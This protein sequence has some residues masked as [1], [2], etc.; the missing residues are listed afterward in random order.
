MNAETIP[1][2]VATAEALEQF[3][4][5]SWEGPPASTVEPEPFLISIARRGGTPAAA[6]EAAL[7]KII[8]EYWDHDPW[9]RYASRV[10][11]RLFRVVA[12]AP[13]ST[14][15]KRSIE[16]FSAAQGRLL[17]L[18]LGP[19][20][21]PWLAFLLTCARH[22]DSRALFP[23]WLALCDLPAGAAMRHGVVAVSGVSAM[24]GV[25]PNGNVERAPRE[26][27][28][29][30]EA[31]VRFTLALG[32][33]VEGTDIRPAIA[34]PHF[35][36]A[37]E[38]VTRRASPRLI[39][40]RFREHGADVPAI[41]KRWLRS[42][43]IPLATNAS[44]R[45]EARPD[46]AAEAEDLL[47]SPQRKSEALD[48]DVDDFLTRERDYAER[49]GDLLPIVLSLVR[50]A[51]HYE[52]GN[53]DRAVQL[54]SEAI[55]WQ[56]LDP[57]AWVALARANRASQDYPS[58]IDAAFR[59]IR[60][61]PGRTAVWTELALSLRAADHLRRAE[62]ILR[63][64]F[65]R[66]PSDERLCDAFAFIL[67]RQ[68][69]FEEAERLYLQALELSDERNE[70]SW[71]GLVVVL[72]LQERMGEAMEIAKTAAQRF[73]ENSRFKARVKG[74]AEGAVDEQGV[75]KEPADGGP[76]S[77]EARLHAVRLVRY[78]ALLSG[79]EEDREDAAQLLEGI[80]HGGGRHEPRVL[81]EQSL[82]RLDSGDLKGA[83]SAL[84][85]ALERFPREVTLLHAQAVV[86]RGVARKRAAG[87][88][89]SQFDWLSEP[90][91]Q[92]EAANPGLGPLA[93]WSRL[94]A[95]GISSD[96]D[97]WASKRDRSLARF[98][99][100][101]VAASG[102]PAVSDASFVRLWA[103]RVQSDGRTILARTFDQDDA[104]LASVKLSSLDEDYAL[105]GSS[106]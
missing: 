95:L 25:E 91:D 105:L 11:R 49:T 98:S 29:Q 37:V 93:E 12:S 89:E 22:Q 14:A 24:P 61:F 47:A 3:L 34:A 51:R 103:D 8:T 21:D 59:A 57:Y 87:F 23:Q 106:V 94:L 39:A 41:A 58:A 7:I 35:G 40:D 66:F 9:G 16:R 68:G 70:H 31:F 77:T 90:I 45:A 79:R 56:P 71:D 6:L 74:L 76:T 54:A 100:R 4:I 30:V 60:R 20:A 1:P 52:R 10:W 97:E 62:Q 13:L 80:Q 15:G 27:E 65:H 28:D 67:R 99:Q 101:L 50:F 36:A 85:Q 69:E 48:A 55:D 18:A 83:D 82:R 32:R 2:A 96:G 64:A 46:F 104:L 26:G 88:S 38:M 63:V 5:G 17:P 42:A 84:H 19:A 72:A 75:P 81:L 53:P 33:R 43:G 92:F 86:R 78:A 73:P 102:A 44:R